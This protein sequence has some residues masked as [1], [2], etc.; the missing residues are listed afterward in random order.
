V[1]GLARGQVWDVDLPHAGP[2]PVVIIT[3]DSAI[4]YLRTVTVAEVTSTSSN[5]P[6]SVTVQPSPQLRLDDESYV[7]CDN[8]ATIDQG[9]LGRLRGSVSP[10]EMFDI[11]TALA[12][13][14]DL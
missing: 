5:A 6:T 10:Q 13:A 14:F 8:I 11:E 4:E 3:R 12:I 9:D 2:R 7:R 1:N